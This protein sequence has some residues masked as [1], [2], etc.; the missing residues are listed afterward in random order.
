M[1]CR[2]QSGTPELPPLCLG[3][4]GYTVVPWKRRRGYAKEALRLLLIEARATNLP[5]VEIT[6]DV[7][8]V[9]SQRV[10]LANGGV[11]HERFRKGPQYG[12][13]EGFRYRVALIP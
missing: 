2:Y 3:H 7:D 12:G 9:A 1:N 13:G 4:V 8:N 6:T 11:L 5:Y 10:V